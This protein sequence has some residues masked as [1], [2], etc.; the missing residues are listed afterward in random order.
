MY[1]ILTTFIILLGA[2][3][4]SFAQDNE[5]HLIHSDEYIQKEKNLEK[6][7][8]VKV[9]DRFFG[10]KLGKKYS[11]QWIKSALEP[12]CTFVQE[13]I[14]KQIAEATDVQ[15]GG[16]NWDVCSIH[17]TDKGFFNRIAFTESFEEDQVEQGVNAFCTVL[18]ELGTKYDL[19]VE[20]LE[21]GGE[22]AQYL[23]KNFVMVI[24][25]LKT[26]VARNG[27]VKLFLTLTYID[28]VTT[29]KKKIGGINEL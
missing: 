9:Q 22:R 17:I 24:L 1:R 6:K 4:T 8:L 25:Q 11:Y 13:T 18:E 28:G 7:P 19:T 14:R 21:E 2:T 12:R 16:H 27:T 29:L 20:S 15:F 3:V 23:G 5:L 10:M 26:G